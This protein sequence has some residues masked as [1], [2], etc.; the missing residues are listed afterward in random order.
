M[1]VFDTMAFNR[2]PGPVLIMCTL[3][4]ITLFFCGCVDDSYQDTGPAQVTYGNPQA[5]G[6]AS[7]VIVPPGGSQGSSGDTVT[8]PEPPYPVP[9]YS[10]DG[11]CPL[12]LSQY[13]VSMGNGF[14]YDLP[15]SPGLANDQ[16]GNPPFIRVPGYSGRSACRGACGEDCPVGRCS[17]M[18]DI[19]LPVT[20][21]G[22][23]GTCTYK[24]VVA[25][26]SHQ[27]CR[28]HDACYDYCT[29]VKGE[30]SITGS[31]HAVC[32]Q[33]CFDEYGISMCVKWA[34]IPSR[35]S[36]TLG[37]AIDSSVLP[38]YDASITYSDRPEFSI[39]A[40]TESPVAL[41]TTLVTLNPWLGSWTTDSPLGS[42]TLNN[43]QD[44]SK[45]VLQPS[46][47]SGSGGGVPM[48]GGIFGNGLTGTFGPENCAVTNMDVPDACLGSFEFTL[49]ADG[50]SFSG[51]YF[52]KGSPGMI[53]IHGR[54]SS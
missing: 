22:V 24:N 39:P 27:G 53:T 42:I 35:I 52:L 2:S 17:S 6:D 3:V 46:V 41:E 5:N 30:T 36:S 45:D 19:T 23:E 37:A 31:C 21:Q 44:Y 20:Y 40:S 18:G 34:D 26:P 47:I 43:Y 12:R 49:S 32:N 50:K 51:V 1:I 8:I 10:Y 38:E 13:Q 16:S 48:S 28:D 29:E 15:Y 54:K 4:I 14:T 11:P 25:C 9:S 33:R 7:Q